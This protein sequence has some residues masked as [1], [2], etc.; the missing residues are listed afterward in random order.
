ML[1]EVLRF[2]FRAISMINSFIIIILENTHQLRSSMRLRLLLI[3]LLLLKWL[4]FDWVF[5]MLRCYSVE[6]KSIRA[7]SSSI[8]RMITVEAEIIIHLILMFLC[9]KLSVLMIILMILSESL[10]QISSTLRILWSSFSL[11]RVLFWLI[12]LIRSIRL[13]RLITLIRLTL[14]TSSLIFDLLT[15]FIRV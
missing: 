11:I 3:L 2:T 15:Y 6:I 7:V 14:T 12:R 13:I 5:V 9:W 1:F 4:S 10:R 8:I